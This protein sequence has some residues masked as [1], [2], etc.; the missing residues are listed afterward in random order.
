MLS[1]D[2]VHC[3]SLWVTVGTAGLLSHLVLTARLKKLHRLEFTDWT[4]E[5]SIWQQV[6]DSV[7]QKSVHE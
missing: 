5:V 2:Y 4:V 1:V 7:L 3:L 6:K